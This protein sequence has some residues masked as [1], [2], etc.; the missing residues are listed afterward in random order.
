MALTLPRWIVAVAIGGIAV[1]YS[2]FHV[3]RQAPSSARFAPPTPS[4]V[5]VARN[6]MSLAADRLR[7]LRIR[8]SVMH[9]SAVHRT[10]SLSVLI[11]ASYGD[12]LSRQLESLIRARWSEAGAPTGI[13]LVIAAVLD[14]ATVV[15]GALRSRQPWVPLIT[16][17]LPDSTPNAACVSILRVPAPPTAAS[18]RNFRRNLLA[19]Q[20][21]SS[22]MGPCLY[23]AAFGRPGAQ[24]AQWL[25][26]NNW[27]MAQATD[28]RSAPP[29]AAGP[30]MPNAR[31]RENGKSFA[32]YDARF[33]TSTTGLACLAGEDG[34]CAQA[35]L[36]ARRANEDSVWRERVVST[37]GANDAV[38]GLPRGR[39]TIGPADGWLLSEMVRALG[40]DRFM[41][42]WRSSEPV[43]DAFRGAAHQ[44]LD[45]WV[46]DWAVRMYGPV[47][48]GPGL[49]A[50]DALYGVLLLI[51]GCL[52]ALRVSR[53]RR[54]S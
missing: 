3:A 46:H 37:T 5:T 49:G 1:W 54:V 42:F 16:A 28:W 41:S 52:V 32:G 40:Q 6:A 14:S 4:A 27:R 33:G 21:V 26:G 15:D 8:D 34:R 30:I 31:I 7:L 36:P 13:P 35:V 23:Y 12:A 39:S 25:S 20:T 50:L 2:L 45:S 24:V 17:F 47:P 19:P 48:V 11:S 44:S 29:A 22:L 9:E 43:P 18:P 38:F 51:G 53:G 10:G